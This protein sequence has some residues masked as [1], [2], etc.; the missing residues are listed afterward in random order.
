MLAYL[1][2]FTVPKY[3]YITIYPDDQNPY[4]FYCVRELPRISRD[5]DNND[6][7][8]FYTSIGRSGENA[9]KPNEQGS[10]GRLVMTVDLSP[11]QEEFD[12]I[13]TYILENFDSIS[14]TNGKLY[15]DHKDYK[16]LKE[17]VFGTP[18]WDKG[19]AWLTLF[20]SDEKGNFLKLESPRPVQPSLIGYCHASFDTLFS[21]E[22]DTAMVNFIEGQIEEEKVD[23]KAIVYYDLE[24]KA[25]IPSLEVKITVNFDKIYVYFKTMY[26]DLGKKL[27]GGIKETW[28]RNSYSK[29][30]SR[31]LH[32]SR[33]EIEGCLRDFKNNSSIEIDVTNLA[34]LSSEEELKWS[35]QIVESYL[36]FVTDKV[37]DLLFSEEKI[38]KDPSNS[39]NGNS[40]TGSNEENNN[41]TRDPNTKVTDDE[42]GRPNVD[43]HYLFIDDETL[44]K[45]GSVTFSLKQK[46]IKTKRVSPNCSLSL[47][48]LTKTQKE[49]LITR[50]NLQN[51]IYKRLYVQV[52]VNADF[53]SDDIQSV[54]VQVRYE[55]FD[56][57]THETIKVENKEPFH[58]SGKGE[59]YLFAVNTAKEKGKFITKYKYRSKV[60]FKYQEDPGWPKGEDGWIEE[61]GT[62][63]LIISYG[64]LGYQHVLFKPTNFEPE[65]LKEASVHVEYL[66]APGKS[67]TA[68]DIQLTSPFANKSWKCFRHYSKDDTYKYT[69]RYRYQDGTEYL[70]GPIVEN[71]EELALYDPFDTPAEADFNVRIGRGL[72]GAELE[73]RV[74]DGKYEKTSSHQLP[75]D[76]QFES[77]RWTTRVRRDGTPKIEWRYIAN[78]AGE[79]GEDVISEWKP[80]DDTNI[81]VVIPS[82]PNEELPPTE[83]QSQL[84]L[85]TT[86]INWEMWQLAF[87]YVEDDKGKKQTITLD[88]SGQ[89][90]RIIPVD[91]TYTS[92]GHGTCRISGLFMAKDGSS[93][94]MPVTECSEPVFIIQDPK[95]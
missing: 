29:V 53:E 56:E 58:F 12:E 24:F 18:S 84:Q 54:D 35:N 94:K 59:T 30:D 33:E 90:E 16:G 80:V 51:E 83:E 77:W 89:V 61:D 55:H 34:G 25:I 86:G 40:N 95:S 9:S 45:T 52:M 41:N 68:A 62:G 17:I 71:K 22:G 74:T 48:H 4:L 27:T 85:V 8:F 28:S 72:L 79:K 57:L 20:G 14:E 63:T 92:D 13:K 3:S 87:I 81:S 65:Y 70:V 6:P 5:S 38:E 91:V 32:S 23:S 2:N 21:E 11:T 7:L 39:T 78:Y 67:D 64:K 50:V 26:D 66:G 15:T 10:L 93:I 60:V 42:L 75:I 36:N 82:N 46:S 44:K 1:N 76:K 73:V 49:N 19:E 43:V 37:L 31:G 69:V 88:P 47:N